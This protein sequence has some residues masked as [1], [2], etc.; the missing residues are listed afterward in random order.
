M[1][2]IP[3]SP[4][5]RRFHV[6]W[7]NFLFISATIVRGSLKYQNKLAFQISLCHRS[8]IIVNQN[9]WKFTQS[10]GGGNSAE[11]MQEWETTIRNNFLFKVGWNV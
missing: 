6:H 11:Y 4:R 10:G 7:L 5:L 9:E 3:P 1:F 8:K 2:L